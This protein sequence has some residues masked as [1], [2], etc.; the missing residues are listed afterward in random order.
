MIHPYTF[1]GLDDMVLDRYPA[2][3]RCN[4]DFLFIHRLSI[5]RDIVPGIV[6]DVINGKSFS[7]SH[8]RIEQLH[9]ARFHRL[10]LMFFSL[11]K[12]A[13]DHSTREGSNVTAIRPESF[14]SF[15]S[16]DGYNGY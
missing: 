14:G 8:D 2:F 7:S 11:T 9:L 13:F 10:E 16:R 12:C 4:I 5:H 6:D 1:S 15:S 3:L